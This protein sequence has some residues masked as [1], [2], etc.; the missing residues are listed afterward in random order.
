VV[1]QS[2]LC[3]P[4]TAGT[5]PVPYSYDLDAAF[6]SF[7]PHERGIHAVWSGA[8]EASVTKV[9]FRC[10]PRPVARRERITINL[11]C[12]EY[13]IDGAVVADVLFRVRATPRIATHGYAAGCWN[14]R[15]A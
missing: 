14:A 6:M 5:S 9:R 4:V 12:P 15:E 7:Q 2:L 10:E 13:V 3:P 1:P 8:D 11:N